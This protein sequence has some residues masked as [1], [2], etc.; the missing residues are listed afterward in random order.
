M[1]KKKLMFIYEYKKHIF[2]LKN[3][4]VG[5][6]WPNYLLKMKQNLKSI[7]ELE[8]FKLPILSNLTYK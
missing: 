1:R 6:C 4:I 7:K 5:R 2:N 8:F 3:K